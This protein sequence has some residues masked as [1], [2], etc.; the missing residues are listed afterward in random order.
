MV[1]INVC[2]HIVP[3]DLR[4]DNVWNDQH[5]SPVL[6]MRLNL[7]QQ[8][9]ERRESMKSWSLEPAMQGTYETELITLEVGSR[10]QP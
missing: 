5:E 2:V 9:R 3:T 1:G 7:R 4:P 10:R 8:Q 6:A